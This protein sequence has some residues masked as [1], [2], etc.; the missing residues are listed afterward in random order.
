MNPEDAKDVGDEL[1]ERIDAW[2]SSDMIP[3]SKEHTALSQILWDNKIGI[4]HALLAYVELSNQQQPK[5]A[6]K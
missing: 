4:S 2:L 6:A 5:D 1:R 3:G